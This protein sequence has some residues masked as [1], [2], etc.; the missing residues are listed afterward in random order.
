MEK[1]RSKI[2]K[3]IVIVLIIIITIFSMIGHVYA[4][5]S[6]FG[7]DSSGNSSGSSV[8]TSVLAALEESS[9]D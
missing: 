3:N 8:S 7:D 2:V 5:F 4:D 6:L 1:L 9:A